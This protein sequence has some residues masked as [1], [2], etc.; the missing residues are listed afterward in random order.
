[1]SHRILVLLVEHATVV[2]GART[3]DDETPAAY[4]EQYRTL[5]EGRPLLASA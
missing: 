5:L 1:M 4:G 2:H 3:L